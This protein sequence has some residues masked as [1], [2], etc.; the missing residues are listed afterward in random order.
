[1]V[2]PWI[3]S[4]CRSLIINIPLAL[5]G[6]AGTLSYLSEP[7]SD[8]IAESASNPRILARKLPRSTVLQTLI[9]TPLGFVP[10]AHQCTPRCPTWRRLALGSQ[11][12]APLAPPSTRTS[13]WQ[14]MSKDQRCRCKNTVFRTHTYEAHT[15]FPPTLPNLRQQTS[16]STGLVG[17]GSSLVCRDAA[18]TGELDRADM[19]VAISHES[20]ICDASDEASS[21]D[22]SPLGWG[23]L[24]LVSRPPVAGPLVSRPCGL[25]AEVL[26]PAPGW[27]T[28]LPVEHIFSA[29][30]IFSANCAVFSIA[31]NSIAGKA[32][33]AHRR[34]LASLPTSLLAAP[35]FTALVPSPTRSTQP[36]L[37]C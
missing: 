1:M 34:A 16:L 5:P 30:H 15:S 19:A 33:A 13:R 14:V 35:F 27:L 9:Y 10:A 20:A 25:G 21:R 6:S 3:A 18:S 24:S 17:T 8:S 7:A 32:T 31:G 29:T 2:A 4:I 36:V 37:P 28:A 22:L 23:S 12:V 11:S 26:P